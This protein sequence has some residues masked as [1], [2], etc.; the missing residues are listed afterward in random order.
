MPAGAKR[1][2]GTHSHTFWQCPDRPEKFDRP[3]DAVQARLGWARANCGPRQDARVVDY[4]E[5]VMCEVWDRRYG[6]GSKEEATDDEEEETG[7][8]RED[9]EKAQGEEEEEGAEEDGKLGTTNPDGRQQRKKGELGTTNP[10]T[11]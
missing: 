8:D 7:E 2:W 3:E 9:E 10:R 11:G 6:K 4:M 5:R 1:A